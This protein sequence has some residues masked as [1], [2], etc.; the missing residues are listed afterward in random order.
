MDQGFQR[1][2]QQKTEK[3]PT[4][5][6]KVPTAELSGHRS[7]CQHYMPDLHIP[8]QFGIFSTF[9]CMPEVLWNTETI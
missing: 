9:I 1:K 4:K 3:N 8:N 5:L 6:F 7:K 2:A